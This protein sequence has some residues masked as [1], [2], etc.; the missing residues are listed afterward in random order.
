M[1]YTKIYFKKVRTLVPGLL[2]ML[3]PELVHGQS[4]LDGNAP[5]DGITSYIFSPM[6]ITVILVLA[7]VAQIVY[8]HHG[9]KASFKPL[10]EMTDHPGADQP[11]DSAKKRLDR[12][13]MSKLLK[14]SASSK[15]KSRSLEEAIRLSQLTQPVL[16]SQA[17][18]AA[19]ARIHDESEIAVDANADDVEDNA[20]TIAEK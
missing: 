3:M 19:R 20:E 6:A 14:A 1:K 15:G 10:G 16:P 8:W 2:I 4:T 11:T 17:A 18:E 9:R 5:Y 7:L 12:E 13:S